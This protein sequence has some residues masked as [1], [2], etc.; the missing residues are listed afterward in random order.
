[1]TMSILD[2]IINNQKVE[3]VS[4]L[5]AVEIVNNLL[6]ELNKRER[7]ILSRR[8]GLTGKENETLEMV[9]AAHN[10]TRERIRQIEKTT[11]KKLKQSEKLREYI[12]NL[13]KVINQLIEEHGGLM[14]KKYLLTLLVKYSLDNESGRE[15]CE[16]LHQNH[17]EFLI[18]KLLHDKFEEVNSHVFKNSY[19]LKHYD[20][21]HL[22]E[23]ALELVEKVIEL[24]KLYKTDEIIK[25]IKSLNKYCEHNEKL[26]GGQNLDVSRALA[27]E[28]FKEDHEPINKHKVLYTILKSLKHIEQNIFGYWGKKDWREIKPKNIND[29][30]YL[31]MKD[32]GKPM[33]F[34]E[35]A[36]RINEVKFDSKIANA[37]TVH[38]ELILDKKYILVGRGLYGLAEWGYSRGTVAE[39]V[40]EILETSENPLSKEEIIEEVLKRRFVK[41]TT[42]TLALLNNKLFEK[43]GE[44]YSLR[45]TEEN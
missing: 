1:M 31:V 26:I 3:E 27:G 10:L 44:K 18:A 39:V 41:K 29:K 15:K 8:Y 9:G 34:E 42:I 11:V 19:K 12:E 25:L 16:R 32:M 20:L 21:N 22:E 14:E 24:K 38:N 6:G 43:N 4:R 36:K 37:A 33:H 13:N 35:I 7:D 5:N 28:F 2:Q 30:I 23:L 17:L 45:K 40:K